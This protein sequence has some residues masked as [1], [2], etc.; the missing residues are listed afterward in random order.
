MVERITNTQRTAKLILGA[1][2]GKPTTPDTERFRA[3]SYSATK[4]GVYDDTN[5]LPWNNTADTWHPRI[6]NMVYYGMVRA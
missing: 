3:F 5:M 6:N 4:L 1:G 2:D